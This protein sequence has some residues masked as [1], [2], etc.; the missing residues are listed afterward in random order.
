MIILWKPPHT[1]SSIQKKKKTQKPSTATTTIKSSQ[2]CRLSN[3]NQSI[4]CRCALVKET[5]PVHGD[6]V[7]L[8]RWWPNLFWRRQKGFLYCAYLPLVLQ[9][10]KERQENEYVGIKG[11]NVQACVRH[12]W[13]VSTSTDT[14]IAAPPSLAGSAPQSWN[15]RMLGK[16]SPMPCCKICKTTSS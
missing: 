13:K 3:K 14:R 6:Y 2:N 9:Q 15:T 12:V 1:V 7:T 4:Y 5:P 16:R 10:L 11:M 8:S